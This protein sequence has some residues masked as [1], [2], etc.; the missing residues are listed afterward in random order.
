MVETLEVTPAA[1]CGVSLSIPSKYV[2]AAS[3]LAPA[4][5]GSVEAAA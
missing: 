5:K 2:L 1:V 3:M 4:T